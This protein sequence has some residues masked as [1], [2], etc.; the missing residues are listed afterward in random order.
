VIEAGDDAVRDYTL[1]EQQ[2]LTLQLAAIVTEIDGGAHT[3]D[4]SPRTLVTFHRRLFEGVRGHAGRMR[5]RGDGSE[6]LNFGPR[7]SSHRDDVEREIDE[8][9]RGLTGRLR[10]FRDHAHDAEY[11]RA[12]VSVGA[13]IHAEIVRIHPFEDGNG[14]CSRL[15]MNA[16]LVH[17]GIP[18]IAVDAVKQEY[19]RVL[20]HY[21]DTRELDPLRDLLLLLLVP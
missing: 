20:N 18:S 8:A 3:E 14:R 7:R 12:A 9:F 6:R 13:W 15:M 11:V 10:P 5:R 21:F 1:E 4:L 2:R 16:V 17:L 19:Y